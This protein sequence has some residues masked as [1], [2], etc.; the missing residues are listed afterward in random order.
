MLVESDSKAR[1]QVESQLEALSYVGT[2]LPQTHLILENVWCPASLSR[3]QPPSLIMT[4]AIPLLLAFAVVSKACSSLQKF[5]E[6]LG[7]AALTTC[8]IGLEYAAPSLTRKQ[9]VWAAPR[10]LFRSSLRRT[11]PHSPLLLFACHFGVR[12]LAA[13]S[14]C[15]PSGAPALRHLTQVERLHR[16]FLAT[17]QKVLSLP[18]LSCSDS[19]HQLRRRCKEDRLEVKCRLRARLSGGKAYFV[20]SCRPASFQVPFGRPV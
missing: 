6:L 14:C 13:R 18:Y 12:F 5:K 10:S 8:K 4:M 15:N 2:D 7:E 16:C 9:A 3:T 1:R 20:D 17:G 19:L 11:A